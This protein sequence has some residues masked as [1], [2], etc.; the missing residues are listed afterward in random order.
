LWS[1]DRAGRALLRHGRAHLARGLLAERQP[2]QGRLS[3]S[4]ETRALPYVW[5]W[6][7]KPGYD[8]GTPPRVFDR[9]RKGERCSAVIEFADGY[10]VCTSRSGLRR[11]AP[12][13]RGQTP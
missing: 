11:A 1:I 5:F 4:G 12:S 3:V 6:R 9:C 10:R 2:A 13:E 8:R 7:Q